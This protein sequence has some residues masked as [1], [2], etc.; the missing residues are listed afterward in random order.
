MAEM[1]EQESS[2]FRVGDVVDVEWMPGEF[3]R[4][5]TVTSLIGTQASVRLTTGWHVHPEI[6]SLRKKAHN[7]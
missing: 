1:Q 3:W 4:D 5:G 6:S 2:D 7:A